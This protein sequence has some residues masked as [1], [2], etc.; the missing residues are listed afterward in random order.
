MWTC[1]SGE[2]PIY[3]EGVERG[4]SGS[5][6]ERERETA[7][8]WGGCERER[9]NP[10]TKTRVAKPCVRTVPMKHRLTLVATE[11]RIQPS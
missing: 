4:K 5:A 3:P 2:N 6:R 8:L 7:R 10:T 11:V 1:G 9:D